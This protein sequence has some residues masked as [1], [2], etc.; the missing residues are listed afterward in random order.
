MAAT[1]EGKGQRISYTKRDE[2]FHGTIVGIDKKTIGG[3]YYIVLNDASGLYR[4]VHP[5]QVVR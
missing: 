2:V 4:T 1:T 5:S 3:P